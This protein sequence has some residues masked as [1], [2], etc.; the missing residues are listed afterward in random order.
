MANY[1]GNM[2]LRSGVWTAAERKKLFEMRTAGVP[3]EQIAIE[4]GRSMPSVSNMMRRER[5]RKTEGVP[6]SSRVPLHGLNTSKAHHVQ[7]TLINIA[8]AEGY[9]YR[10]LCERVGV[11]EKSITNIANGNPFFLTVVA[12][13]DALDCQIKIVRKQEQA[14]GD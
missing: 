11:C 12:L 9:S 3:Y 2:V 8:V 4:L 6:P 5:R 1:S 13:A 10:T 14:N 7:R